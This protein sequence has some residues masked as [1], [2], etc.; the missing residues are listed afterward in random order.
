MLDVVATAREA[1]RGHEAVLVSHQLPVWVTRRAV[2]GRRLWHDP[3]NRQCT[4]ASLTSLRYDGDRLVG[5]HYTEPAARP[6]AGRPT[7]V[8]R[9]VTVRGPVGRLRPRA[10]RRPRARRLHPAS[11]PGD[12][13]TE[14]GAQAGYVSGDGSTR[15][16]APEDRGEPGRARAAATSPAPRSTWP[17][18][19]AT[20]SCSTP[21]TPRARPAAP[22]RPTSSPW[23][24]TTPTTA[25]AC[26]G[27]TAPTTRAPRRRSSAPSRCP[28]RSL[29][30]TDGRAV[31]ALQGSVPLQA[32][33][34]TVVLDREGRV[35]AR[36]L[37]LAEGSILRAMVDDVL[38]EPATRVT[39]MTDR[40]RP[41]SPRPPSR[42][43]C[44]SRCRSPLVA[45]LVSFASP[46]V[47]PLVPGYLGY[48]GGMSGASVGQTGLGR[49]A[50][51]QAAPARG[52]LL[53]GVG[54]F[55]A[56]FTLVFV[57]VGD[58]RRLART[59]CSAAG[60]TR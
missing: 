39:A 30:D 23:R 32:V 1:A 12:G 53:A 22:R 25:C 11:P 17:R 59:P 10:C 51:R 33:P 26:S 13:R 8:A 14:S 56:G 18:G 16:W 58:A 36:V 9:G 15:T 49:V 35:A 41:T 34:T 46:C 55:V 5:L 7:P 54:L 60:R 52:R 31:A 45:G 50:T 42:G 19:G 43:R 3:R 57:A 40:R 37:G 29:A 6:A 48:L 20:S 47:L 2:E 44:C 4:L 27:S 21:G 38:A 24:P 28:T